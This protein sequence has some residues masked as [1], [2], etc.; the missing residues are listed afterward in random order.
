MHF[1][2]RESSQYLLLEFHASGSSNALS[3]E[4]ARELGRLRRQFGKWRRP[5]VVA[6]AHPTLFC[7]GGNLSDYK[8][9]KGKA[10]GLKVNR[11]ITR[12]LDAFAAWPTVKLALIEGDV[13]GGGMEW[14]ARFDFRWSAPHALFGFWQRRIGLSTGWGGGS[15]WA[16][17][18][19]EE[20]VR[21]LLLEARL[22]GSERAL[23]LGVVDRVASSADL[24]ADLETW[25]GRMT[26]EAVGALSAWTAT[27]ETQIFT[28]LWHSPE[29]KTVLKRWKG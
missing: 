8:K 20:R 13:L 26:G 21:R 25:C 15:A 2:V 1:A 11:E 17:L 3:L 22:F 29:H 16:R 23:R 5:V 12:H 6:S 19:G 28:S 18:L 24:R 9:L 27:R 4:A 14:L 10:A 7:A